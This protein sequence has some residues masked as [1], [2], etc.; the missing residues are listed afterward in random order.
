MAVSIKG[1][2]TRVSEV[3]TVTWTWQ[4]MPA[5]QDSH[6]GCCRHNSADALMA[7]RLPSAMLALLPKVG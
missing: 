5:R 2:Q 3:E 4:D 6:G 7:S 1:L